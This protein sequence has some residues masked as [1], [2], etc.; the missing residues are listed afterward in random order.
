M[1]YRLGVRSGI[2]PV[3]RLTSAPFD[4]PFFTEEVGDVERKQPATLVYFGWLE[5]PVTD[6]AP[7]WFRNPLTG[8]EITAAS[9]PWWTI[10]DFDPEVGDIKL[11]WEP[12]RFGWCLDL[13]LAA[14]DGDAQAG[15]QMERWLRDWCARNPAYNGPNWKCGQEASIRVLHLAMASLLLGEPEQAAPGLADLIAGHLRRIAPTIGYAIGQDN[16]HGTSEAAALFVGGSWLTR[17][18]RSEGSRWL[19]LGRYWLENR[20]DRLIAAD[21]SFSQYSLNYH[22]MT[23]DTLVMA[24]IWRR[25]LELTDFSAAFRSRAEAASLWLYNMIDPL[26][27]DGPNVGANDGAHLFRIGTA[28]YRDYRPTVQASS[29]LFGATRAYGGEGDW[30]RPLLAF[31]VDLPDA[32]RAPAGS[33]RLDD[34][35]YMILRC[36]RAAAMLRYPR[37]R[38]R[39]SQCD[40]L[41]VD[42]WRDHE[43]LL[44][45]AGTY[46]YNDGDVWLDYFGGNAGHNNIAFDGRNAMPRLGRFL[47]GDWLQTGDAVFGA[48]TGEAIVTDAQGA[49]HHRKIQLNADRLVITDS[50][51]G[52]RKTARLQWRLRPGD[53]R[54][55][56]PCDITDGQH[57]LRVASPAAIKL[58]IA[59][60]WRSLF[61]LSKE[62]IPVVSVTLSE[63]ANIT[64]CYSWTA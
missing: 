49:C 7:A 48:Q 63:P 61:Y 4:G 1:V 28:P 18:G 53:W 17:I 39:P 35:G 44:G 10:P 43:N 54:H 32:V 24:E 30:N 56:G 29:V 36:G 25:R 6:Q 8:R 14:R 37:F 31:G 16:N 5:Q 51:S 50:V 52:F 41:H 23:L 11:L 60:G 21:G 46:S 34:G 27:G 12:S 40:A 62:P 64:T 55:D 42:L 38:F 19:A 33:V 9:R 26:G 20:V 47:F 15:P 3:R 59:T 57:R 58:E 13:A 22:R 2:N 45:D